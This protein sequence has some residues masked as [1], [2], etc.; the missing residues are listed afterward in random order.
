M[1]A[2]TLTTVVVF[3]PILL[4]EEQAGQLFRDIALAIM[5]AVTLSLVVSLTLIPA[6]AGKWL[7]PHE[8]GGGPSIFDR[9]FGA[10]LFRILGAP[11]RPL[12][13]LF[14]R[15]PDLAAGRSPHV[16]LDAGRGASA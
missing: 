9:I 16:H 12:A 3:A 6:A 5:A 10:R 14:E 7:T 1:L 2:S 4:I 8:T 15:M 13:I 11:F